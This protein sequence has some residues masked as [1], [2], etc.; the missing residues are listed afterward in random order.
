MRLQ[1][2]LA[3]ALVLA[4]CLPAMAEENKAPNVNTAAP[5]S[6]GSVAQMALAHDLYTLGLARK[7]AMTVLAA[8]KLAAEIEV[9][10]VEQKKATSGTALAGQENGAAAPPDA[11]AMMETARALAAEDEGL[12]DL[13]ENTV[14]EASRA[15]RSG[16][17]ATLSHLAA[18]QTDTWEVPF[19]ADSSSE[20]AVLGDGD[21]NLDVLVADEHGNTICFDVSWSDKA[22][23]DFVPAWNGYFTV[24]VQNNGTRRNSYFLLT[25]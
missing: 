5:G 21:A 25:N 10:P 9:K 24:T 20:I 2:R 4:L 11:A 1:T 19:Y 23:C 22:F 14:L 17:N 6:K 7:D 12:A 13:I 18:G 8:A 16:A 15:R 3:A